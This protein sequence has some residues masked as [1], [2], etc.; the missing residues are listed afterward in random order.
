MPNRIIT[1]I[2]FCVLIFISFKGRS[3]HNIEYDSIERIRITEYILGGHK[4]YYEYDRIGNR[5]LKRIISDSN[6][7]IDFQ[8]RAINILSN[9][10][11][12]NSSISFVYALNNDGDVSSLSVPVSYYLSTNNLFNPDQ[13]ILIAPKSISITK[14][15]ETIVEE[16]LTLPPDISGAYFLFVVVD[17]NSIITETNENNNQ[18][19]DTFEILNQEGLTFSVNT[20]DPSCGNN[21]GSASITLT[22]G[23]PPYEYLW[24]DPSA[25]DG[26]TLSNLDAGS[27]FCTV[28]DANGC[29]AVATA[30]LI[31]DLVLPVPSF[32]YIVDGLEVSFS[33]SS[34]GA[35]S[36]A[37]DFGN[38]NE[39]SDFAPVSTYNSYESYQVCLEA[40]NI[41]GFESFC[42]TISLSDPCLR[43]ELEAELSS[44]RSGIHL[45]F[46]DS[47][48]G[49]LARYKIYD[50][51][52]YADTIEFVGN[53][54]N[55]DGLQENTFYVVEVG[56]I[57]NDELRWH[58][59][60]LFSTKQSQD[61]RSNNFIMNYYLNGENI[62][63]LEIDLDE[64]QN[65]LYMIGENNNRYILSKTDLQG[66]IIWTN[67]INNVDD[68][69]YFGFERLEDG[70]VVV[71]LSNIDGFYFIKLDSDGDLLWSR[72]INIREF[73]NGTTILKNITTDSDENIIFGF[74]TGYNGSGY[75]I[76]YKLNQEGEKIWA[77]WYDIPTTAAPLL[78]YI[79][80]DR[81]D[82]IYLS[83]QRNPGNDYAIA[84]LSPN[85]EVL[86]S[87]RIFGTIDDT[88][89]RQMQFEYEGDVTKINFITD[90]P[91]GYADSYIFQVAID[92]ADVLIDKVIFR[93]FHDN[94]EMVGL[95]DSLIITSA[96]VERD[97]RFISAPG[98]ISYRNGE[99]D[100]SLASSQLSSMI[101]FQ[102]DNQHIF[103]TGTNNSTQYLLK[104]ERAQFER[105]LDCHELE[106]L[107]SNTSRTVGGTMVDY[108]FRVVTRTDRIAP[109]L[110]AFEQLMPYNQNV[111]SVNSLDMDLFCT[112]ECYVDVSI[113]LAQNN[114]C[115]NE[116]IIVNNV[117][118]EAE[119]YRWFVNSL[120]QVHSTGAST[121]IRMNQSGVNTII[122]IGENEL[123]SDTTYTDIIVRDE[124][125]AQ[126][127]IDDIACN[128][129][130]G[131]AVTVFPVGGTSP[132]NYEWSVGS[133]ENSV[134]DLA[135]GNYFVSVEDALGCVTTESFEIGLSPML[136]TDNIISCPLE[137]VTLSIGESVRS[138][139]D[140]DLFIWSTGDT[141]FEITVTPEFTTTYSVTYDGLCTEEIEVVVDRGFEVSS[142]VE[143]PS[144]EGSSDG[145]IALSVSG[146]SANMLYSW[147]NGAST[148]VV[149]GLGS[150]AYE[151]TVTEQN[152]CSEVLEF[153]ISEPDGLSSFFVV[154]SQ[155]TFGLGQGTLEAV[156]TGGVGPFNYSWNTGATSSIIDDLSFGFYEVQITDENQCTSTYQIEIIQEYCLDD[157]ILENVASSGETLFKARNTI[158]SRSEIEMG[159]VVEYYSGGSIRLLPGYH[160]KR[161]SVATNA[162]I[163]CENVAS[164]ISIQEK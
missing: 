156:V 43:D 2:F 123:C 59:G 148:S 144:C 1:Y 13:D 130:S 71:V 76:L 18:V 79:I 46:A 158:E 72:L 137:E 25:H 41:C 19:S 49:G 45:F 128:Q 93:D 38:G 155:E 154:S 44:T 39:S 100:N 58:S 95:L 159:A 106:S 70:D 74:V 62:A 138:N 109:H 81:D 51:S 161:G 73:A 163:D 60:Y 121:S 82:N 11:C 67:S 40:Q 98:V 24:S 160:A 124:I 4:S 134:T 78:N 99:F 86:W 84:K 152:G 126:L 47:Y 101:S 89:I 125:D 91:R 10:T 34:T 37:W 133:T 64:D 143:A 118:T 9:I 122:L 28:T 116:E 104:R 129:S 88:Y 105:E 54:L 52:T 16:S 139:T 15:G 110:E 21:N 140:L 96:R 131:G 6:N 153:N 57:C 80:T 32:N 85:G 35:D 132:Y 157:L 68:G 87:R 149:E 147:S 14:A 151:V 136:D 75:F 29:T 66:N 146:N 36:Y 77:E 141:G 108:G 113:G 145:S 5:T 162:I 26:R 56:N 3:Q 150:G 135:G 94:H 55:F 50:S 102:G 48:E 164:V 53:V 12:L 83:G 27:Y 23:A 63:P 31:D 142:T 117:G 111:D 65:A 20:T 42:S 92:S 103:V 22:S 127:V 7:L 119:Q 8:P 120:E 112:D 17:P 69:E 90:N 97:G 114:P 107:N 30:T 115:F 33:I 61:N